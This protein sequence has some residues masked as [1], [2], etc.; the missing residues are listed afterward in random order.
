MISQPT[1]ADYVAFNQRLFL[2]HLSYYIIECS[3]RLTF[4]SES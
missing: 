3:I 1:C 4:N 2:D